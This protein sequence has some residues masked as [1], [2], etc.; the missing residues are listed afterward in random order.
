MPFATISTAG[1]RKQRKRGRRQP[2]PYGLFEFTIAY[3][4]SIAAVWLALVLGGPL[5][6]PVYF[7]VGIALIRFIGNRIRWWKFANDIESVAAVKFRT[8][9]TWPVSIPKF[10]VTVAIAKWL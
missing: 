5:A 9:L 3:L 4:G 8:M 2:R 10:I 7:I 1:G 6:I